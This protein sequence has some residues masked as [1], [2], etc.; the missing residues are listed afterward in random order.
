MGSFAVYTHVEA[1]GICGDRERFVQGQAG[2]QADYGRY[3]QEIGHGSLAHAVVQVPCKVR[4]L[5]R[6]LQGVG[7]S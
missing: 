6:V 5:G 1:L 4:V 3:E 7:T 2:R